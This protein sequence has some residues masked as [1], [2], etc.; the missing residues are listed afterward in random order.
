MDYATLGL[1]IRKIRRVQDLTQEKL[2]EYAGISPVFLSQIENA[3]RKPSLETVVNIANSLNVTIDE[4]ITNKS[5]H[6]QLKNITGIHFSAE[7]LNILSR[8]FDKRSVKEVN[9]LLNAFS[10]LLDFNS[11]K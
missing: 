11:K 3:S 1:N 7:Q 5:S 10:V 6:E 8:L 2:S 4:L 9:A